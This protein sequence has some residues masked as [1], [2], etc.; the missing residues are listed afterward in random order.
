[1]KTLCT[2]VPPSTRFATASRQKT[3]M[4]R[5]TCLRGAGMREQSVPTRSSLLS[6]IKMSSH[7]PRRR[8]KMWNV[9][10]KWISVANLRTAIPQ[11]TPRWAAKFRSSIN[12]T[13]LLS[14]K[15][16]SRTNSNLRWALAR[17]TSD[18]PGASDKSPA[19][20]RRRKDQ[21]SIPMIISSERR[22]THRCSAQHCDVTSRTTTKT[23]SLC[24]P[25]VVASAV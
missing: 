13:S 1:M 17:E 11:V 6:N 16:T 23:R 3:T 14:G 8:E 4:T 2:P 20:L 24:E 21:Q 7:F 9:N 18:L 15:E 19:S 22:A 12:L 5:G 10:P 25:G